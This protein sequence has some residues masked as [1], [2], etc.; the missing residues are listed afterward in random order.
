MSTWLAAKVP[1]RSEDDKEI[2]L[3]LPQQIKSVSFCRSVNWI[4]LN[5]SRIC[6]Q[7][8]RKKLK[9]LWA[10]LFLLLN[11]SAFFWEKMGKWQKRAK[12]SPELLNS[13]TCKVAL[14]EKAV[15]W[16][17][18][19]MKR[20]LYHDLNW[21]IK[22]IRSQSIYVFQCGQPWSLSALIVTQTATFRPTSDQYNWSQPPNKK[23]FQKSTKGILIYNT[24]STVSEK[25]RNRPWLASPFTL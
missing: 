2:R 12:T 22:I 6:R 5:W 9:Q 15:S 18:I 10:F 11:S 8:N 14:A 25:E 1:R 20:A 4:A 23:I 17:T 13:K 24:F 3:V 21:N 16:L 19:K 7:F